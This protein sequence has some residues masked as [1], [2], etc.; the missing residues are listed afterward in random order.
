MTT[1]FQ[2]FK[3]VDLILNSPAETRGVDAFALS[4]IKAE[5]QLRRLVT[6][7]VYQFPCFGPADVTSLR[8]TLGNNCRVY[9]E[10]F[11]QG[12]DALYPRSVKDLVGPEYDRLRPRLTEAIEHRNKIFHGQLTSKHLTREDLLGYVT[13]VRTWCE[14]LA[15]N[16][17][18]ELG[19]DGFARN[20]FRKSEIARLWERFK[21]QFTDVRSYG[22]FIQQH[23]QRP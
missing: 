7:L 3:T 20:S 4:L 2:E 15:R 5:R 16:A 23:M 17:F 10:G 1:Y 11:E 19:Y 21:L 22:Q 12:F 18:G 9:F 6:H 13:D 8:Q 14:A